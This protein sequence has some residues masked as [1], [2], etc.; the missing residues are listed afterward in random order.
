MGKFIGCSDFCR[1]VVPHI[2]GEVEVYKTDRPFMDIGTPKAMEEA[3][4]M[5]RLRGW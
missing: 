3:D 4:R 2:L 1:D 5:W